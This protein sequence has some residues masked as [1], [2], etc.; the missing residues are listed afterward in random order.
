[1]TLDQA[2]TVDGAKFHLSDRSITVKVNGKTKG[3]IN[4]MQRV[5]TLQYKDMVGLKAKF[6]GTGIFKEIFDHSDDNKL[7][8]DGT[9]FIYFV[10]DQYRELYVATISILDS[11]GARIIYVDMC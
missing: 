1:M 3:V 10:K 8:F 9:S 6:K 11:V 2:L 7:Y 5:S 4:D